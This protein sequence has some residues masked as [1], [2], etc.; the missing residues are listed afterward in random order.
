MVD[1]ILASG[2][3]IRRRLMEAAGVVFT[4]RAAEIDERALEARLQSQGVV[5]DALPVALAE[6][7]ALAVSAHAAGALVIG[8]DQIL[9]VD[10]RALGKV[11]SLEAARRRLLD[12]RGREHR[13]LC[14][15]ALA[16][17]GN[18]A[19]RFGAAT[20]IT[21]RRF[22]ETFLDDYL[23]AV[24]PPVLA[25]VACYEI[26]GRGAQLIERIEGDYFSALG[27]PVLPLLDALRAEGALPK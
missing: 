7:K 16:R 2:S 13:L 4:Q 26:E 18:V 8:A 21:L 25:S 15:A 20:R 1:V 5:L 10:G 3:A 22:S 9:E 23:A 19:W 27:L 17:D 12:L 14:G 24:G 11:D 6:A